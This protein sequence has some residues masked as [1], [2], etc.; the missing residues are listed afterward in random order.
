MIATA[1]IS[2]FKL[3]NCQRHMQPTAL[4]IILTVPSTNLH[5]HFPIY[6]ISLPTTSPLLIAM[7]RQNPSSAKSRPTSPD[8]PRIMAM[9][10]GP[11]PAAYGLPS[12]MGELMHDI[13]K[14]KSPAYTF[15]QTGGSSIL[16]TYEKRLVIA[17]TLGCSIIFSNT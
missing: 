14:K 8:H 13:S 15:G 12:T 17:I 1:W 9:E 4:A 6:S 16:S 3:V 5:V 2:P 11:G 7:V 10:S